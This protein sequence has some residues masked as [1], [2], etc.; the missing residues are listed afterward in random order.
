MKRKVSIALAIVTVT[1]LS[2]A[3]MYARRGTDLPQVATDVVSRGSILS[4]INASGTL[5][6]VDT[7]QVGTQV[8]GAIQSLGADFNSIV[9]KGQVLARLDPSIIQAEIERAQANLLGAEADVERLNV[10]LQDAERKLTRARELAARQ[11]IAASELDAAELARRTNEA[12]LKAAAA[13]VT[14]ARAALS[15]AQVNL[16]KT[17]IVSPID[18][19]V[20]SRSVDVGQTVAASLQAPTLFTIAADLSQMQ[21]KA[22]IDESDL[23]NIKDGQAVTFRVDAY[24]TDVFSGRVKQ[25]R[26]NPVI[27]QNVVT[28]A[29]IITA[30][31]PELKL[32]PGMT[33]TLS[34]EVTRRDNVLR[35]PGA[36]LRFK[37]TTSVLAA[38]GQPQADSGRQ[39]TAGRPTA[40]SGTTAPSSSQG[41]LWI[42]EDERLRPVRV[43]VG[44]TDGSF[45]EVIEGDVDEGTV[46]ATLVTMPGAAAAAT[47]TSSSGNPLMGQPPRRF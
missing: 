1:G 28:Y 39:A 45:T 2:A 35:V 40:T 21:L 41:T 43:M 46:L 31:N 17:V 27:E 12:Q 34:V 5:E 32:K 22:S 36:A 47:R 10:L 33:A 13:Q 24:P 3:A 23:G 29:A 9:K 19:I 6:A 16:Q 18:G 25:V 7:V 14:Q 44:A 37:P 42:Y 8:S 4:V 11:L 26:L 30:S 15:Q 20:I 38:L